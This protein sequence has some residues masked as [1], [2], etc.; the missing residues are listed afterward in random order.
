MP[1]TEIPSSL[2]SNPYVRIVDNRV[3]CDGPGRRHRAFPTG[4]RLPNN[5]IL[6]GFRVARDHWMTADDAFY[7]SRS[8]DSGKT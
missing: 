5:D 1:I 3:I 8:S 6:V 7:T 4:V 2:K